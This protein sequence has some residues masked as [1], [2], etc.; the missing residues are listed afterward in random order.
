MTLQVFC[1][2]KFC[3]SLFVL[4][5]VPRFLVDYEHLWTFLNLL[6]NLSGD[7]FCLVICYMNSMLLLSLRYSSIEQRL[8]SFYFNKDILKHFLF[9]LNRCV[10]YNIC[11]WRKE[12]KTKGKKREGLEVSVKPETI[13]YYFSP[14]WK[15]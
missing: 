7:R 2:I 5:Y 9:H 6:S 15:S 11:S 14:Y 12:E 1:V 8:F 4:C 13:F 10:E 3:L